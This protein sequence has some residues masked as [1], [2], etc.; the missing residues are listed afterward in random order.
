[1]RR[2]TTGVG[3]NLRGKTSVNQQVPSTTSYD[4]SSSGWEEDGDD[5]EDNV[6]ASDRHIVCKHEVVEVGWKGVVGSFEGF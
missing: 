4:E 5:D 6:R 2:H 3:N 1:M